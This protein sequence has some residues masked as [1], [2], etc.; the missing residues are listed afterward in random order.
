MKQGIDALRNLRYKLRM[1][2]ILISD[3]S[4]IYGDNI[5]VVNNT[6][7]PESILKKKRN[8]VCYH[9]VYESVAMGESLV[10]YT[11]Q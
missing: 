11:Q 3:P 5:S 6:S 4:Y 9:A 2:S 10:G 1:K 7:K 8:S